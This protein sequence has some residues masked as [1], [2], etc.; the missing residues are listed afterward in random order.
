MRAPIHATKHIVQKSIAT[1]TGGTAVSFELARS[2]AV[3][4]KNLVTEVEEGSTIKQVYIELWV[5]AGETTAGSGQLV[6]VK[7][8]AGAVDPTTTEMAALNNYVNKKNILFTGMGLFNDQDADAIPVMRGWYKIPRGKQRMGLG[9][10]LVVRVFSPT[11]DL[12]ICGF[13][14]YKEYT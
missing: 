7:I 10:A 3:V 5:R 6:L 11:I 2:V 8:P 1:V 9:D 4:D 12:H 13:C 14:T